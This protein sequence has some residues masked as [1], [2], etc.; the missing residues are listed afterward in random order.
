MEKDAGR[1][2]TRT[3]AAS[4]NSG[5]D[6]VASR[7]QHGKQQERARGSGGASWR[8]DQWRSAGGHSPRGRHLAPSA[9]GAGR[10]HHHPSIHVH[11]L[12]FAI[13]SHCSFV[14]RC[15]SCPTTLL[16]HSLAL[17][18]AG[19]Y[20]ASPLL[21]LLRQHGRPHPSLA[22]SRAGR[23][24]LATTVLVY[25]VCSINSSQLLSGPLR[26]EESSWKWK[27]LLLRA[28]GPWLLPAPT[29]AADL[30]TCKR[31]CCGFPGRLGFS[32]PAAAALVSFLFFTRWH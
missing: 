7:D 22:L 14:R 19:C 8:A 21:L 16:L 5:T 3:V 29:R 12:T 11:D 2:R 13:K 25:S 24:W 18:A 23:H 27:I 31:F 4:D 1:R 26:K 15:E 9:C 30:R 28:A 32:W 20:L 10:H 6:T 17:W